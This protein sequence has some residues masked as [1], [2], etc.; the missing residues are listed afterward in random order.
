MFHCFGI[1]ISHIS[2]LHNDKDIIKYSAK[3]IEND[4]T[5]QITVYNLTR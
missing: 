4:E 5:E 3:E 1:Q 2:S